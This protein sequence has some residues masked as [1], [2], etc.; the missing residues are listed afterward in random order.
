MY[1]ILYI[2]L[3]IDIFDALKKANKINKRIRHYS[4]KKLQV[5]LGCNDLYGFPSNVRLHRNISGDT[6][7][8]AR[9]NSISLMVQQKCQH[10]F[11]LS[12]KVVDYQLAEGKNVW[13]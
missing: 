5:T 9:R 12:K 7:S 10:L 6:V 3:Y 11:E 4:N 13:I 8:L 2:I 1:Y